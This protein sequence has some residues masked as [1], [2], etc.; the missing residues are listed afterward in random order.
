MEAFLRGLK[1][2]SAQCERAA[3]AWEAAAPDNVRDST[4]VADLR[5]GTLVVRVRSAADR[6][7]ADRWVRGGGLAQVRELARAP[8][9]RVRFELSGVGWEQ[10]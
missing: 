6:H 10:V 1:R 7:R 8:V 5:A 2:V 4:R 3:R 9:T